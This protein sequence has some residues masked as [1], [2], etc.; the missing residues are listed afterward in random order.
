[1]CLA[2]GGTRSARFDLAGLNGAA[3]IEV[4]GEDRTLSARDGAFEDA[5]TGYAVHLYRVAAP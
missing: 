3:R 1:M 2:G 4:R 5:F